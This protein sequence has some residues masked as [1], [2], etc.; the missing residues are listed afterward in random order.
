[1]AIEA[2]KSFTDQLEQR[3]GDF[4]PLPKK[5]LLCP[6]MYYILSGKYEGMV[7]CQ[8]MES[9][10]IRLPG[11]LIDEHEPTRPANCPIKR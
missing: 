1:M 11:S 6:F 2:K 3:F 9:R 7:M 8:A 4:I 5:C 10:G